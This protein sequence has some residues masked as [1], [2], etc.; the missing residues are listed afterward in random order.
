M[1]PHR[2]GGHGLG[3]GPGGGLRSPLACQ[4]AISKQRPKKESYSSQYACMEDEE[5]D[6]DMGFGLWSDDDNSDD[7]GDDIDDDD[8]KATMRAT[9]ITLKEKKREGKEGERTLH[10]K[11]MDLMT[12][13]TASGHFAEH[14]M[15]G[16]ILGKPLEDLKAQVPDSKP[17]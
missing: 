9:G 4:R 17:E 12:L 1:I 16:D 10:E 7:D 13:Q 6:D 2:F 11:M 15:I 14:K 5:E 3:L 8:E